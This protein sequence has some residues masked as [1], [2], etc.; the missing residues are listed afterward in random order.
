[1]VENLEEER[2]NLK[3]HHKIERKADQFSGLMYV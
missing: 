3:F 1:M 2:E